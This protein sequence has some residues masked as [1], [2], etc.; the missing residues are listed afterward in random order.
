MRISMAACAD[1]AHECLR[2]RCGLSGSSGVFFFSR[3]P[4]GAAISAVKQ[5]VQ[6]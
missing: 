1:A 3:L 2:G 6:A 4:S 5:K